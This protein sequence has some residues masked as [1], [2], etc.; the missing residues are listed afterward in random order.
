MSKMKY[1]TLTIVLSISLLL[2]PLSSAQSCGRRKTSRIVNGANTGVNEFTMMAGLVQGTAFVFCGATIVSNYYLLSSAHCVTGKAPTSLQAL[3]GDWDYKSSTDTSY[4]A[5]YAIQS[6][7]NHPTFNPNTNVGDITILRTQKSIVY[8]VAVGPVCLPSGSNLFTNSRVEA[9][10]WGSTGFG[11]PVSSVQ[12]KVTLD[13]I[14]NSQCNNYYGNIQASEIC[15]YT[16][17]RDSCQYDSGGPLYATINGLVNIV[18]IITYGSG[19]ASSSPSVNT[20]ITSYVTWIQQNTG[21][22]AIVSG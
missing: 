6:Y 4:A 1:Y 8:N 18:G 16:S 5:V 20:R 10:G 3:V 19:C 14:S 2:A 11:Y 15:T 9:V 13:V 21:N 12:K 22:T 17:G 7:L